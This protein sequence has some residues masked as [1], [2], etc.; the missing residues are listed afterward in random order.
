MRVEKVSFKHRGKDFSGDVG[1]PDDLQ[2]AVTMLGEKEVYAAFVEGYTERQKRRIRKKERKR[3]V[4]TM[5]DLT[6]DQ[7]QVLRAAGLLRDR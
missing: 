6:E 1:F 3:L 7:I 5:S 2:D 4:V